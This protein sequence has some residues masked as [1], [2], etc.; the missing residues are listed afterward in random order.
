MR[1][2][3]PLSHAKPVALPLFDQPPLLVRELSIKKEPTVRKLT[4]RARGA[5]VMRNCCAV[6]CAD[7]TYLDLVLMLWDI[8]SLVSC[9]DFLCGVRGLA[10]GDPDVARPGRHR[11]ETASVGLFSVCSRCDATKFTCIVGVGRATAN[12]RVQCPWAAGRICNHLSGLVQI[13]ET[14]IQRRV[15]DIQT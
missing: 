9:L 1:G 12:Y 10:A 2:S 11:I 14:V 6:C 13:N 7:R 4:I 15:I 8:R 3:T 5:A